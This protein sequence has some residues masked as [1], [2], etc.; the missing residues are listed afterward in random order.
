MTRALLLAVLTV[1]GFWADV[2]VRN[3]AAA[4][5]EW[6][7]VIAA[8]GGRERLLNVRSFG[9]RASGRRNTYQRRVFVFPTKLWLRTRDVK[10]IGILL[11]AIDGDKDSDS[12]P[13]GVSL[14]TIPGTPR[15]KFLR[16]EFCNLTTYY[17]LESS[18][19]TPEIIGIDED[20]LNGDDVELIYVRGCFGDGAYVV[21]P[22]SKL[23]RAYVK[24][25]RPVDTFPKLRDVSILRWTFSDY[26]EV[27]GIMLP[28]TTSFGKMYYEINRNYPDS[29]FSTAPRWNDW[30]PWPPEPNAPHEP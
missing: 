22:Q 9:L 20:K 18:M 10:P 21:D 23:P 11:L 16:N 27:D 5:K 1:F 12:A 8:K 28:M 2:P 26:K 7:R 25:N 3:K 13:P 29:L 4:Q 19:T 30:G 14:I 15:S 17:L 24:F 6:D